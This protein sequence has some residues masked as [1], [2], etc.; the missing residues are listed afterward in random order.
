MISLLCAQPS[1]RFALELV[2]SEFCTHP[3]TARP[4]VTANKATISAAF[5]PQSDNQTCAFSLETCHK[6]F[7]NPRGMSLR[8]NE[9]STVALLFQRSAADDC[10]LGTPPGLDQMSL[11]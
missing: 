1:S 8:T 10:A 5:P 11:D 6:K 4:T 3:Q 7:I 9:V 2:A